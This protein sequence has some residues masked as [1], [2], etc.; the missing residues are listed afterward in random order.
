MTSWFYRLISKPGYI[1][2][3]W[4]EFSSNKVTIYPWKKWSSCPYC[5]TTGISSLLQRWFFFT[6]CKVRVESMP[7]YSGHHGPFCTNHFALTKT[8][9]LFSTPGLSTLKTMQKFMMSSKALSKWSAKT[10]ER[11]SIKTV[12]LL[13]ALSST[14]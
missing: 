7:I 8:N 12:F 2:M 5:K 1:L 6:V 10:F 9:L 13:L 4:S 14:Q 11:F 3:I